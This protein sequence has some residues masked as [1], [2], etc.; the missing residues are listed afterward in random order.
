MCFQDLD[1]SILLLVFSLIFIVASRLLQLFSK[2]TGC[3]SGCL[4]SSAGPPSHDN[5]CLGADPQA[6]K[7]ASVPGRAPSGSPGG[8]LHTSTAAALWTTRWQ[9][10]PSFLLAPPR[11][12][13]PTSQILSLAHK[14]PISSFLPSQETGNAAFKSW[15]CH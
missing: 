7:A 8:G 5:P 2:T 13:A 3:F 15:P 11:F 4:M 12:L 14:Y 10:T 6:P 1:L 9:Q